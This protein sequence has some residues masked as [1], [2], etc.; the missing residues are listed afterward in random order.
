MNN[1]F[2]K[3]MLLKQIN[4]VGLVILFFNFACEA[5]H[6]MIKSFLRKSYKI[7]IFKYFILSI[8]IMTMMVF[9]IVNILNNPLL[10]SF[11]YIVHVIYWNNDNIII[12][13]DRF[14]NFRN[15]SFV[16]NGYPGRGKC[17]LECVIV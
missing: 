10:M 8:K 2:N 9:Y 12:N 16:F 3:I 7:S 6:D 4:N 13:Q 15:Y 14:R 1:V 5:N 11:I 17:T